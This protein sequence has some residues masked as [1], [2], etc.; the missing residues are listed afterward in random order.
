M[1]RFCK[2]FD[3]GL[4]IEPFS[5]GNWAMMVLEYVQVYRL[6]INCDS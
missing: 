5:I 1:P 3:N 2:I 4:Y 6:S